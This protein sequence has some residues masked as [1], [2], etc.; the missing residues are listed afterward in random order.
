MKEILQKG[1]YHALVIDDTNEDS[2]Q[3]AFFK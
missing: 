1:W 2:S 3:Q